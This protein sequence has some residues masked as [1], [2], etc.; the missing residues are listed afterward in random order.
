MRANLTGHRPQV[1]VSTIKSEATGHPAESSANG[2]VDLCRRCL[3]HLA[4]AALHYNRTCRCHSAAR[5]TRIAIC[6]LGSYENSTLARSTRESTDLI[7]PL[8]FCGRRCRKI[9]IRHCGLWGYPTG[10]IV[11]FD[12]FVLSAPDD[13]SANPKHNERHGRHPPHG[14][15]NFSMSAGQRSVIF[16]KLRFP[17]YPVFC[18]PTGFQPDLLHDE[19]AQ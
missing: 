11:M 17:H 10:Q 3:D 7:G 6:V 14:H 19:L 5:V 16:F 2:S 9:F 8:L 12:S 4:T 13:L 15:C 18:L 1:N